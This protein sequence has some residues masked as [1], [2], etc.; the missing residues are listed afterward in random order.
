M[1]VCSCVFAR[2]C[3]S[4]IPGHHSSN[5]EKGREGWEKELYLINSTV[6]A[7]ASFCDCNIKKVCAKNVSQ[8]AYLSEILKKRISTSQPG[9]SANGGFHICLYK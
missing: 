8:Y 9:I 7:M 1:C 3:V 5:K 2:T 4:V 6:Q